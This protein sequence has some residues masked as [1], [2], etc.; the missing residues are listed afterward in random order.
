MRVRIKKACYVDG[1]AKKV[2]DIVD[3]PKGQLLIGIGKATPVTTEDEI[4]TIDTVSDQDDD[5][6]RDEDDTDGGDTDD[7]DI[8]T[9]KISDAAKSLAIENGIDLSELDGTGKDGTI[10]KGDVQKAI[11]EREDAAESLTQR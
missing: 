10:T 1:E 6:D 11:A 2:G 9:L 7:D 3:T 8:P 5:Q 4:D